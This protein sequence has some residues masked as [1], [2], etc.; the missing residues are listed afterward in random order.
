MAVAMD[1]IARQRATLLAGVEHVASALFEGDDQRLDHF[2]ERRQIPRSSGI[3]LT[4]EQKELL[5]NV[6]A[7]AQA[8]I[9]NGTMNEMDSAYNAKRGEAF[10]DFVTR[11]VYS[12][13]LNG[14]PPPV[15]RTKTR[16]M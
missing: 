8:M 16:C 10:V 5:L 15:V 2:M 9:T 7:D 14:Y 1:T 12:T 3:V 13:L 11:R 4:Q 6:I